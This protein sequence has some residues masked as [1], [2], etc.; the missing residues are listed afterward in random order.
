MIKNFT[1]ILIAN[2]GEIAVRI[3]HTLRGM[4]IRS[5]AVYAENEK[6]E[7]H[8]RLADESW[9]LPGN[10]LAGTYLNIDAIL[11]IARQSGADAIHPGYG[12]LSENASFAQKTEDSGLTFIGPSPSAIDL[13]GNKAAAREFV[14]STGIPVIEGKTGTIELKKAASTL[15]FPLLIKAAA[16][17]GGKGMRI[18]HHAE[19]LD[20]AL[21]AAS[22]EALA[23]FGDATVYVEKYIENPR[24][25][26]VQILADHHGNV[27]HLFERECSVQRRYQK[28][29]EEAPAKIPS[30]LRTKI[31]EAAVKIAKEMNYLNAGTIEFLVSG[32]QFFFLEMNTRIQVE[33][34]VTE[35]ITGTDIVKEQVKIA[36]GLPLPWSQ[37]AIHASGHSMEARIYAENPWDGFLPTPGKMT[38]YKVPDASL[39]RTDSSTDRASA[40]HSSYDP[41]ISKLTATGATR[42]EARIKLL[43]GL[44]D[45][46]IHGITTNI[47]YLKKLLQ[48]PSFIEG[49]LSTS[50]CEDHKTTL[51]STGSV[52]RKE[53]IRLNTVLAFLFAEQFKET[54][55]KTDIWSSIGYWRNLMKFRVSVNNEPLELT[56]LQKLPGKLIV[57]YKGMQINAHLVRQDAHSITMINTKGNEMFFYKS[58]DHFGK[59]FLS[60]SEGYFSVIRTEQLSPES[61]IRNISGPTVNGKS[62]ITA[63]MHG[64][65]VKVNVKT[66]DRVKKGDT[67]LILESMKMENKILAPHEASVAKVNVS[68]GEMVDG[69]KPLIHLS[70]LN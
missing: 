45:Y 15:E 27:V 12:F 2:R 33:H 35:Q 22:R 49:N 70:N 47:E 50:F 30:D 56:V 1:K 8:V 36:A 41:M 48:H 61:E 14:K 60:G 10:D 18:V 6:N 19:E 46:H 39:I 59:C 42:E 17:G 4:G 3:I 53:E 67:L 20:E 58:F 40:V 51:L 66:A 28:I 23:Y 63:P 11:S 16:G 55:T 62:V 37:E 54:G 9:L 29:I 44:N 31:T 21:Q 64:K 43:A 25:I 57:E 32:S 65:I 52:E 69:N 13:M 38:F 68:P 26:E 34:P 5:V 24:H 7:L